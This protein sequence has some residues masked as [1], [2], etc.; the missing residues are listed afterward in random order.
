M[1]Y[2]ARR[3]F[4]GG[5][6]VETIRDKPVRFYLRDVLP[7]DVAKLLAGISFAQNPLLGLA[8]NGTTSSVTIPCIEDQEPLSLLSFAFLF[9]NSSIINLSHL[10]TG[11][12]G[13]SQSEQCCGNQDL[14]F[15]SREVRDA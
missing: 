9:L 11:V 7:R 12:C 5:Q 4:S 2:A 14:H 13:D 6:I 3:N 10:I 15:C 8:T 1:P